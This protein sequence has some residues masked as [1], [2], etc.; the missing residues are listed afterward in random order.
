MRGRVTFTVDRLETRLAVLI[1]DDGREVEVA[2]RQLPKDARREGAVLRV[3]VDASG[4]P[5]WSTAA[6][7]TEEE[8]RRLADAR[9]RLE[10]LRGRDPGGDVV[11]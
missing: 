9:A 5:D 4:D 10:R 3:E 2:R 11:L 1:D 6:I 7:D 8:E